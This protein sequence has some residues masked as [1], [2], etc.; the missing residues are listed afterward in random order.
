MITRTRTDLPWTIH[1]YFQETWPWNCCVGTKH[2][3]KWEAEHS[4]QEIFIWC[5]KLI[6]FEKFCSLWVLAFLLMVVLLLIVVSLSSLTV[7]PLLHLWHTTSLSNCG[8]TYLFELVQISPL[9]FSWYTSKPTFSLC[10]IACHFSTYDHL[11]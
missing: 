5:W 9:R 3:G 11:P 10:Q 2:H 1:K 4:D 6:L 8:S 7:H